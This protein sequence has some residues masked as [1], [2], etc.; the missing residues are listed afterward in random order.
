MNLSFY[1]YKLQAEDQCHIFF[2]WSTIYACGPRHR[3]NCSVT[4]NTGY[5]YD[6]SSLTLLSYNYQVSMDKSQIILNVCHSII[7]GNGA[8][9]K[10]KSAS[11]LHQ[12]DR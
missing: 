6:L 4:D 10:Q 3:T 8:A 5:E 7:Y 1:V 12:N 2:T 11:C 9:C